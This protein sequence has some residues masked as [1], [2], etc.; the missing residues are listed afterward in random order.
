MSKKHDKVLQTIF[1]DHPSGN[2]HWSEIES[3]LTH[4]GAELRESGGARVIVVLNSHEVTLHRP[5]H[6][7][8]FNR[9]SLHQLRQFLHDAGVR[10]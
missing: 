7:A 5:H 4:L 6:G 9:P 8:T 2:M 3:M 10:P 1:S